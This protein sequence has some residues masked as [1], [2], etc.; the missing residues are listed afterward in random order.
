MNVKQ[1]RMQWEMMLKCGV[2]PRKGL[3]A[4]SRAFPQFKA[5]YVST[6]HR[7][8]SGKTYGLWVVEDLILERKYPTNRWV[9]VVE[10]YVTPEEAEEM[11]HSTMRESLPIHALWPDFLMGEE[12]DFITEFEALNALRFS[13]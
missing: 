11:F 6:V 12:S 5:K 3:V 10:Y 9:P 4:Y 13:P 2:T 7:G 1:G 8:Y